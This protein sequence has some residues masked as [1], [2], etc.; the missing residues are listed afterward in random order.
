[1]KRSMRVAVFVILFGVMT[2]ALVA[3]PRAACAA[4]KPDVLFIAVDD[5][6]DWVSALGGNP[7]CHTPNIDRL[8]ARGVL[9][10]NAHCAA[11]AC[12]PSRAALM[13]GIR[14]STSGVY[15]NPQPWRQSPVL[16]DA[17]TLTQ[18]FMQHG[19]TAIGSGKIF[20]GA[21]P[22]P[23]SWDEYWPSKTQTRPD[24]PHPEEK[25]VS[26]LNKGHFDWGPVDATDEVMGDAQVV[27]WVIEQLGAKH[28]KPMFLACGI[29]KPH[30]PWYVPQKYFDQ[31]PVS[32]VATP[33]A[34]DDDLNDIPKAGIA[35]AK[36]QGDH[37]AVLEHD[38]WKQ[39][40]QGYLAAIAFTDG[41]VGR[42]VD[43]LDKSPN[44]DNTI[45][46]FW[47]DHGWHLGE[48]HHWRKFTLWEEATRVPLAMIVPGVTR[49]GGRCDAPVN[50]LDIYPTLLDVCD[51]GT[52]A[53]L[54]GVSLRPLL[55]D[56]SAKWDRPTVTTHG[57]NNH[58]VRD[59]RFRYIRYAD[60]SEEL[61]DH[62]ADPME[63]KNLAGDA[64][65]D[66][67]KARLTKWLPTMNA[68]DAPYEHKGNGKGDGDSKKK[69]K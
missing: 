7:Q 52:R 47:T 22:D 25:S 44:R 29:Y 12:N 53:E 4:E 21:Y 11:P 55:A 42:L 48:K 14:P 50:L 57:R 54:E 23:E 68:E 61:Y 59:T 64:K 30:L 31:F 17:V 32:D 65:Y 37:A 13:T 28:D 27:D 56:P 49:P 58:A 62:E 33:E 20:H 67:V 45:V 6:N 35:I 40:V 34:P 16:K 18:H 43:A 51:V 63:W 2:C 60:G 24:D 3:K 10:T 26:G 15:H 41:Q 69:K 19:Y 9:F 66:D 5:L 38:Q 36:P 8:V 39:A 1:M 46:V